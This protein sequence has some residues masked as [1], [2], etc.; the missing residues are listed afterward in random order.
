MHDDVVAT[1][2]QLGEDLGFDESKQREEYERESRKALQRCSR[3]ECPYH[4]KESPVSVRVCK[5]CAE[6]VRILKITR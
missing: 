3:K 2:K 4:E 1:W 5:G 6:V